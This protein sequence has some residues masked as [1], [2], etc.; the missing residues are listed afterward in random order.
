[1]SEDKIP[2]QV[3]PRGHAAYAWLAKKDTK[4]SKEGVYKVTLVLDKKVIPVG[5]QDWGK[6]Q[7]AGTQW[8]K[9]LIALSVSHGA[10]AFGASNCPVKDGDKTG[11]E[12][13]AG[14]LL[15][16]FKS[17]FTPKMLDTKQNVL[18]SFMTVFSG[19]EIKVLFKVKPQTVTDKVKQADGTIVNMPTTYLSCYMNS[20]MLCAKNSS[21]NDMFGADEDGGFVVSAADAE[22]NA[23]FG[24]DDDGVVGHAPVDTG[25]DF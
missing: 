7:V 25:G 20:I 16:P 2:M 9:D 14:K 22:A 12:E 1:M 13:F 3:T 15:I 8:V 18:P 23:N 10:G 6:T 4:F 24:S 11:K 19:D 21:G 5:R 17:T